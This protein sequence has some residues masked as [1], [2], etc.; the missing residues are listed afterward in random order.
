MM[1]SRL[2]FAGPSVKLHDFQGEEKILTAELAEKS[3][4]ERKE[5]LTI[6]LL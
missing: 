4:R 5:E 2:F 1:M 6:P 3:R